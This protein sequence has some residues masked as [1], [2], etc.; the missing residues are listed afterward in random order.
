MHWSALF[1]YVFIFESEYQVSLIVVDAGMPL[2]DT[3]QISS[4]SGKF[5]F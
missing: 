5:G 3:K 4:I 2:L 1:I